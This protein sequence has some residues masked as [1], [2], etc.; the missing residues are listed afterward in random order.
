VTDAGHKQYE[1][2]AAESRNLVKNFKIILWKTQAAVP[3]VSRD[4][5]VS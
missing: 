2:L 4:S 3:T 1:T 5:Y